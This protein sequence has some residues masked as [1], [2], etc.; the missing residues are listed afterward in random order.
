MLSELPAYCTLFCSWQLLQNEKNSTVA[1]ISISELNKLEEPG[2]IEWEE[3]QRIFHEQPVGAYFYESSLPS[4]VV[5]GRAG[6]AIVF[7]AFFSCADYCFKA[8]ANTSLLS[9]TF[10]QICSPHFRLSA[11]IALHTYY[12]PHPIFIYFHFVPAILKTW[13]TGLN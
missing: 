12:S 2:E 8:F 13:R 4:W 5:Q 10:H 1:D 6:V 7:I 11:H 9:S 3:E